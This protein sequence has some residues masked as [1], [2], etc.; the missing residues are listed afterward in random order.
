LVGTLRGDVPAGAF[1]LLAGG[2]LNRLP[3]GD[4][5][6]RAGG[7]RSAPSLPRRDAENGSRDGRAPRQSPSWWPCASTGQWQFAVDER[8][9][10]CLNHDKNNKLT[11]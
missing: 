2:I 9:N 4:W 7:R 8:G 5:K 6:A 10:G 11:N 1:P 3:A